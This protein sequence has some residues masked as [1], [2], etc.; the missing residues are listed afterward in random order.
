MKRKEPG[1]EG[2]IAGAVMGGTALLG[3][4]LLAIAAWPTALQQQNRTTAL[5]SDNW[6]TAL[7]YTEADVEAAARMIA[8]ENA[9]GSQRLHIELIHS[10]LRARKRGQSLFDRITAGSG[11]G[12]QGERQLGGGVRPVSTEE[13]ATPAFRQLARAV[14]DGALPSILPNARKFFEPAQQDRA[15][16]IGVRARKKQAAGLLLSKQEKRLLHYYSSAAET[17]QSWLA[18]GSKYLGTVDGVEFFT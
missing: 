7:T 2:W 17:R 18:D 10:Q 16:A 14:L 11:W 9:R 4:L 15:V 1:G 5:P 8:S 12:P 6:Q 3:G 13:A